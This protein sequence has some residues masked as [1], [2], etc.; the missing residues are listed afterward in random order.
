MVHIRGSKLRSLPRK[1][2]KTGTVTDIRMPGSNGMAAFTY[3]MAMDQKGVLWFT[4]LGLDGNE[5][6]GGISGGSIPAQ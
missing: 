5:G 6:G 1:D 2:T 4:L 3:G